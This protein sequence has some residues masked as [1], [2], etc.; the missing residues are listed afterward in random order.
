M[1]KDVIIV[2]A[3]HEIIEFCELCGYNIIGMFDSF[4]KNEYL[5]YK[6]LGDDNSAKSKFNEYKNIPLIVT[7]DM[8][9]KRY[10][11]VQFYKQIGY[12]FT[13]LV[14]PKAIISRS[15]ILGEG[16]VIQSGVNVSSNVFIG[17]F[18]KLNTYSNIMHDSII[19]KYT[20]LAPNSVILG[21]VKINSFCYIGSNS[22]ILPYKEIGSK[23]VIGAGSVVTKNITSNVTVVGNP[24][25]PLIKKY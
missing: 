13:Q 1:N 18:V 21:K 24:A 19:E 11:L 8:P 20:T 23:A 2:G 5:G 3:F 12:H 9:D 4:L 7:P 22:T 10:R 16:V 14:S 15:A 6:I 25:K 17:D